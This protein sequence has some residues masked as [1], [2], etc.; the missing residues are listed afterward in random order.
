MKGPPPLGPIVGDSMAIGRVRDLIDRYA[1][2][3]LAVL[4][5]GPT[6]TG[7]ELIARHIHAQSGRGGRFVPVNCGALPR[8]M[9][10]A[11]LFGYERGAFS[12]AVKQHRGHVECADGGTLF[13]DEL[14]SLPLESQASLLRALDTGEI[15]RL[16]EETERYVDARVVATVQNDVEGRIARGMFRTD[17]YRRVAGAVLELPPL[18]DRPEDVVPLARHFA[19]QRGQELEAGTARV[20]LA[21][22]WPGNV[23][24][25][26]DVIERA[27]CA[28]RDGTLPASAVR[29]AIAATAASSN[30]ELSR[31]LLA[32]QRGGWRA[33]PAA[34]ALG[35][36]RTTLFRRLRA[37]G[38]SLREQ[39][40][41]HLLRNGGATGATRA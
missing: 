28:G 2:T 30:Q 29:E 34:T 31:I 40:E 16:G 3:A 1:P 4:I 22:T 13:L 35:V 33:G 8:E 7:K 21:Y 25:L 26:R 11:L 38:T 6:G 15:R 14:L 10:E 12:G 20:L 32:C 37:L 19:M 39:R 5:V 41:L 24:E 23:R 17:L 36:D 9:V 18:A 27:G